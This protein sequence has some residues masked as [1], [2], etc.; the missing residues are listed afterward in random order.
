MKRIFGAASACALLAGCGGGNANNSSASPVGGIDVRPV[1]PM[2]GASAQTA[3]QAKGT[4][5]AEGIDCT[6]RAADANGRNDVLGVVIGMGAQ[7]A[8][9]RLACANTAFTVAFSS[10]GGF[11]VP[12][13]PGAPS[14]RTL[15]KAD[16]GTQHV[17]AYLIGAPGQ[18]KVYAIT[19]HVEFGEGDE[20]SADK[21]RETLTAKYGAGV[22]H[23]AYAGPIYTTAYS[24]EGA[25][26]G[27]ENPT[28]TACKEDPLSSGV[29]IDERCG[30]TASYEIAPKTSNPG[31]ANHLDLTIVDQRA[32]I[33]A[34]Q[35]VRA[36]ASAAIAGQK[37]DEVNR[38]NKAVQDAGDR[39]P[40][41]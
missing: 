25:L 24:A 40:K 13:V 14:P 11:T 23:V 5:E 29:A 6:N 35:A 34:L 28:F 22:Q 2:G 17:T 15:L 10:Q 21:L 36:R 1:D 33:Q 12:E 16:A 30:M 27:A 19:R 3:G 26:L 18:E 4:A 31:L 20:P 39:I 32:A 38:A 8:Y 7:E 41:L 9:E 37:A